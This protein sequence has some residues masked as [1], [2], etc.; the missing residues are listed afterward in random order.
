M[1][2]ILKLGLVG[3]CLL[4]VACSVNRQRSS[5]NE[6]SFSNTSLE[7]KD[8][9]SVKENVIAKKDSAGTKEESSSNFSIKTEPGTE[10]V[11][12]EFYP[13]GSLKSQTEI[14]GTADIKKDTGTKKET[15][16][17]QESEEKNKSSDIGRN[18]KAIANKTDSKK[19]AALNVRKSSHTT[20][21]FWILL[22]ILAIILELRYSILRNI[23]SKNE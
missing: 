6:D 19:S 15:S 7:Q 20:T 9:A 16:S 13:D 3:F 17:K 12:K 22:L 23:F 4:A 1:K 10:V 11:H 5:S 18:S 8:T 21:F 14:K 2:S